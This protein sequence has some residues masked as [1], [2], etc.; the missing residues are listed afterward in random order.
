MFLRKYGYQF[1]WFSFLL[2]LVSCNGIW[3]VLNNTHPSSA[4]KNVVEIIKTDDC[5]APCLFGT[6]LRGA[7]YEEIGRLLETSPWM[8]HAEIEFNVGRIL[9]EWSDEVTPQLV[10][11][12]YQ[13]LSRWKLTNSFYFQHNILWS[14]D[15]VFSLSVEEI[16]NEYGDKFQVYPFGYYGA[17]T[18]YALV[19]PQFNGGVFE[20]KVDCSNPEITPKTLVLGFSYDQN[21]EQEIAKANIVQWAGYDTKLPADCSSFQP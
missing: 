3:D 19:Y 12:Q 11:E 16:I 13:G 4:M 14:A 9:W 5:N 1:V 18:T 2:L 20:A 17:I 15:I 21:I 10:S 6:S 8:N 7:T